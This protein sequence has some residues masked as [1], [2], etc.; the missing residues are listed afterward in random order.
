MLFV[1][2]FVFD[3]VGWLV[4]SFVL[5]DFNG[6]VNIVISRNGMTKMLCIL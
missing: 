6:R 3:G 5:C 2:C 4:I 1:F